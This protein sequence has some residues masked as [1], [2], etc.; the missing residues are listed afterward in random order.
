MHHS[1]HTISDSLPANSNQD[2][3]SLQVRYSTQ[4]RTDSLPVNSN[5][6]KLSLQ[7]RYSTQK[8]TD[9][10]TVNSN[11]DN[12]VHRITSLSDSVTGYS[13]QRWVF[14]YVK[15]SLFEYM[16]QNIIM[17]HDYTAGL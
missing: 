12:D 16:L 9:S 17:Y 2:K 6:D 13:N 3:L 14:S 15:F 5:Q 1:L 4:K 10:L 8:R 7:V 11:Q